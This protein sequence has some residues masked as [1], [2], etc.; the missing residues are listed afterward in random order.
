[1]ACFT[2]N[3]QSDLK[4]VNLKYVFGYTRLHGHS[5]RRGHGGIHIGY[6]IITEI[7]FD[8][9]VQGLLVYHIR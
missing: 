2:K 1:M 3:V 7:G 9:C 5:T 4:M 8:Y 6:Q